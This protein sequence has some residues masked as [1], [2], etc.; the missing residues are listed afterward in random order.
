M[1]QQAGPFFID[2]LFIY[3][4]TVAQTGQFRV[5]ASLSTDYAVALRYCGVSVLFSVVFSGY[6]L[7]VDKL[8]S[9][10]PWVGWIAVC[11]VS[12][13]LSHIG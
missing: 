4:S 10:V 9:D 2:F 11:R 8:I 6:L 13:M 7:P 5:F 3:L 1:E 12:S